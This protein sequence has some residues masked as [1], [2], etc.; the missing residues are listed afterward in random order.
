MTKVLWLCNVMLPK[1]ARH[2][3]KPETSF[4]GWLVG[5]SNDLLKNND[6]ELSLCF[7]V[8]EEREIV[9]GNADEIEFHSFYSNSRLRH[10]YDSNQEKVFIE[11][12]KEAKPD[13]IHIFGTEYPH[14]LAMVKAC[15]ELGMSNRVVVNIQGLASMCSMHYFS[16]LPLKVVN[17]ITI[18][19]FIRKDSLKQQKKKFEMRG[20]HEIKALQSI[21]H[22]I[23]R[24][25][26]DMACTKQI[27]STINY[28]FCNETLRD[29]FYTDE[30][31]D[32]DKC[33]KKSIFLSQASYPIKGFH[34][35]LEA[36]GEIA[37]KNPE[38]HIYISGSN[39]YEEIGLKNKLKQSSYSHYIKKVI[40][41][42]NL[43]SRITFLGILDEQQ[44]RDRILKSHV[45]VCPSTIE[46]S[47]NS[48]GEAMI[49]GT[50]SIASYVGGIPSLLKHG[51]EGF[52][53]QHDAPYMLAHYVNKLF[54]D[55]DLAREMSR[56]AK[57]RA[58]TTHCKLKNVDSVMKVY[59][60]M[61][62]LNNAID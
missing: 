32:L 15:E 44:M 13:I 31:W 59:E 28:H 24:T 39:I 25:D 9:N 36:I 45:F 14:A 37:K 6:I 54:L 61:L 42:F 3:D 5:L 26:W 57:I 22:V 30:S 34:Y 2:L 1:I 16:G 7:P 52:L 41:N 33:I 55:N 58:T 60:T 51:E 21:S 12:V 56:K 62:Q 20:E 19:D 8:S 18:R 40:K 49:L 46:N 29:T 4:G 53:Y 27:T 10:I 17:K 50:P 43:Q 47:P 23:G 11:I 38:V 48:L 35:V